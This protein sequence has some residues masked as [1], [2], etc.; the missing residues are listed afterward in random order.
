LGGGRAE[1]PPLE[2]ATAKGVVNKRG[3]ESK[4]NIKGKEQG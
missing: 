2:G 1:D 4:E 3:V